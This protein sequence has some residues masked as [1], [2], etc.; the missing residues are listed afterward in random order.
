[1]IRILYLIA[2]LVLGVSALLV[3]RASE[4][5]RTAVAA[6]PGFGWVAA[7]AQGA[8]EGSSEHEHHDGEVHLTDEQ[9]T[10]AGI[11]VAEAQPGVLLRNLRVPG[12]IVPSGERIARVSVKLLATVTELPK[13]LGDTVQKGEV[14]AVI[15]SREVADAKSEYLAARVTDALQEKLVTRAKTLAETR[16]MAENEYLRQQGS[17]DNARVKLDSARQ[18]LFALGLTEEQIRQLPDQRVET[19]HRQELRS[20]IAGRVAERRVDLGALVGREGLESELFIIVDLTEVWVE[21]AVAPVDLVRIHEGQPVSVISPASGD[22]AQ[23]AIMFVSPLLDKD[24]RNARVVARLANPNAMWRPGSFVT[25]SIVLAEDR[26]ALVIPETALQ[27][28]NGESVAFVRT[29]EGFEKRTVKLGRKDGQNV[30]VLAGLNA[31]DRIAITNTFTLKAE[32]GKSEAEH[33]H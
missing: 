3:P 10:A 16:S 5:L 4:Q 7:P 30:E 11:A 29:D 1:M 8:R 25:A 33:A 27:T 31:G 19:L 32:L 22:T 15:E 23:A 14:V 12:T 13:R 28:V 24:T 20:P 18:K 6:I 17:F 2:G 26:A 21:L 9:I